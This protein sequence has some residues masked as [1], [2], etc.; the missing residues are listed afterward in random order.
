MSRRDL[1][2]IL[3]QQ[4]MTNPFSQSGAHLFYLPFSLYQ[5]LSSFYLQLF[6]LLISDAMCTSI[7]R[8]HLIILIQ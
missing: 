2:S 6:T 5:N 3:L 7:S 4:Q 1:V 8:H